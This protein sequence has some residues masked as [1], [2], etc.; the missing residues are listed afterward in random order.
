M[1]ELLERQRVVMRSIERTLINFKKL[2]KNKISM[3]IIQ[4]RISIV[5]A[6]FA[7]CELNYAKLVASSTPEFR[8]KEKYFTENQFLNCEESF[9]EALDYMTDRQEQLIPVTTNYPDASNNSNSSSIAARIT[10]AFPKSPEVQ[11]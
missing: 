4:Q 3:P 2:G 6:S 5:K 9:F 11:R 7:Q 1:V 8:A 10:S